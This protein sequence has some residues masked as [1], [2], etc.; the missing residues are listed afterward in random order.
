MKRLARL[1]R[2][3][4]LGAVA[5][6][7]S[8]MAELNIQITQG[9]DKPTPIAIVPFQQ[10]AGQLPEDISAIVNNDFKFSGKFQPLA[11]SEMLS[12]PHE[13]SEV[14]YRDWRAIGQEYLVVGKIMNQGGPQPIAVQFEL[15]DV[16]RQQRLLAD[17][18]QGSPAQL[19]DIAHAI[20]DKVYQRITGIPG[21]FSTKMLYVTEAGNRGSQRI[22][23]LHIADIDGAREKKLLQSGQPIISPAW[24]PNGREIAYVSFESGRP[25]IYRQQIA[26]GF[27]EK[28]TAFKGLNG[29]P[30]W[31]PDGRRLAVTLSKDGNAEV[32]VLDIASRSLRALT[33]HYA[34]DTEASWMPD[35][36]SLLF[37]SDR[38]G[39]PQIYKVTLGGGA[40][41]RVTFE[42]KNNARAQALPDGKGFVYVQQ[43][44]GLRIAVQDSM[45]G[46]VSVISDG[47]LD[48]SPSVAPNGKMVLYSSRVGGSE[49]LSVSSIDGNFQYR[50]PAKYSDVREPA[51]SPF[52]NR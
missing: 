19:R 8:A 52:M 44:G 43:V 40:V 9:N 50:L 26:T 6:A 13:L 17:R 49:V 12:Q 36:N 46:R 18:V 28:L 37:T 24:S 47:P 1:T 5:C 20:S 31:S 34:I 48:K 33:N 30:S 39:K 25:A 2:C 4:V 7:N 3:I 35:G 38:T 14:M 45:S 29:A 42:G 27:R 51:W 22:F 21:I 32:Y 16:Y 23:R 11:P 41:E 15:F 10:G